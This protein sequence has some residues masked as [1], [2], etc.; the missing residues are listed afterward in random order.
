MKILLV[1]QYYWPENSRVT[2]IA[3]SLYKEGNDVTVLTGL[4]NYPQGYIYEGYRKGENRIQER[5]GVH[6]IRAK[7][8]ERRHDIFHR[9]LN[10]YSFPYYASKIAKRLPNDFDVVLAMEESPI[11]LVRPA[12]AYAKKHNKPLIMYEMDLWPESLLAGGITHKSLI[13]KHYKKVSAKIY[14]K[15]DKILVSTKEHIDYIKSLPKCSDLDIDYLPQYADTIFEESD[16]GNEDNGVIDL[17]FAG[18]IGKAQ[19]IDTII[20]AA[21]LLKDDN[22]F[23]FHIIGSGS[24]L[25]N[26][27]RLAEELKTDNVIFYGQRPLEEMP[28]LYRIADAMLVTLEDKPYANMTIPGKVQSYM[29]AGK[30]VI[31][32]INGS[33][34]NFIKDNG[35]GFICKSKDSIA[36]AKLIK[37]L[38]IIQLKETGATAKKI[39]MEKYNKSLF[40]NKLLKVIDCMIEKR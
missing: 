7:L 3:E 13:Y 17:M 35:I 18:N 19:S 39:Y 16:Y 8:I 2:D 6:I 12:I 5:N 33:C 21:A 27:K 37:D 38:D 1:T 10:Y 34:A 22:R 23:K 15:C 31:G 32:S 14:S 20:R 26:V 24:E 9:L 28:Q 25:D 11:M 36:L 30:P 4:P 40:I 29:A